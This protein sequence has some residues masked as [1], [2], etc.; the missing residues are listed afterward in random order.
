MA[1]GHI[2]ALGSLFVVV[3]FQIAL[4]KTGAALG[5]LW[6][7]A[8]GVWTALAF[9]FDTPL[10]VLSL[11]FPRWLYST[12]MAVLALIASI[13]AVKAWRAPALSARDA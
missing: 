1:L 2:L 8:A 6:C 9:G 11:P 3:L 4:P 5:V 10:D 12:Y 7:I 13:R